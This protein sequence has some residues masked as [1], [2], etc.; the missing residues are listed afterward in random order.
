MQ[1][2]GE[3]NV[4]LVNVPKQRRKYASD[5]FTTLVDVKWRWCLLI[6][7]LGFFLSWLFF[8]LLYYLVI[9]AHGD[10]HHIADKPDDW[11]PC[12]AGANSWV[13]VFI[14]S[15]VSQ[16]TIGYGARYPT[17]RCPE[18]LVLVCIQVTSAVILSTGERIS[19]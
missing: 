18:V 12:I 8:S 19:V 10:L 16:H 6:F 17:E 5:I 3:C 13:S 11:Q 15:V 14:F 9:L 4:S 2:N 7:A 1:K